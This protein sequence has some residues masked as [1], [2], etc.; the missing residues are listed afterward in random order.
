MYSLLRM[1]INDVI[2]EGG[3][4]GAG[5]RRA[6][7]SRNVLVVAQIALATTLLIGAGLMLRSFQRLQDE[8][9]GFVAQNVLTANVS[10]PDAKYATQGSEAGFYEAALTRLRALPGVTTASFIQSLPF[11]GNNSS[12]SYNIDGLGTGDGE[13][14]PHGMQRF[15]DEQYFKAM[16]IPLLRGRMF[17]P[18]DNFE[19]GRVVIIDQRLADRYFKG[20]D[21]IGKRI[22]RAD[23]QGQPSDPDYWATVIGV[24]PAIKHNSL[25]ESVQKETLYWP[26]RQWP[27]SGGAF[28]LKTAADPATLIAPMRE[29]ILA[30]DPE[31]PLFGIRTLDERIAISLNG[32]RAPMLLLGAFAA[33]ALVLSALGIYGVLAYSV[34]QRT[35]ELGVRMAIGAGR[36]HIL[37]LILRHGA[38]LTVVG[39]GLGLIGA[40]AGGQAMRAQLFGVSGSDPRDLHRRGDVPRGNRDAFLLPAGAP[41]HAGRSPDC[42]AL[43]IG[44]D[45]I[46][47]DLRH[48]ARALARRPGFLLLGVV[49]LGLGL[50]CTT[51]VFSMINTFLLRDATRRASERSTGGDWSRTGR[52]RLRQFVLSGLPRLAGAGQQPRSSVRV[53]HRTGLRAGCGGGAARAGATGERR[54][55][56]SARGCAP[57]TGTCWDRSMTVRPERTRSWW[58]ASAPSN[59]GSRAMRGAWAAR[60]RSTAPA[61]P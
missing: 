41:R 18:T 23:G 48:A 11:S 10:L 1:N 36:G 45:M 38:I 16:S 59:A 44:P 33:V 31:Q 32:R 35:S 13:V 46:S 26:I 14:N 58:P 42:P 6:A 47:D 8:A 30:V 49:A 39:L 57:H 24:V 22:S 19:S 17:A 9:P 50:A 34:G 7:A 4:L 43:R 51:L 40:F 2:K 5:G 54:L 27:Q 52:A 29:A 37:G 28:V 61:I 15:V 25:E 21:P 60:S 53:S 12:G 3:R 56:R 20:E 55:F